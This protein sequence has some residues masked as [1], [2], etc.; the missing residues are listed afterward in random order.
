MDKTYSKQN[1]STF[2]HTQ[3]KHHLK[4]L[5]TQ[6]NVLCSSLPS[7]ISKKCSGHSRADC[8]DLC[9]ATIFTQTYKV[10]IQFSQKHSCL[11]TEMG[12][13]RKKFRGLTQMLCTQQFYAVV[14]QSYTS[15]Q[16]VT[17][18]NRYVSLGLWNYFEL[19][20]FELSART[21]V[22]LSL[23]SWRYQQKRSLVLINPCQF[24]N[25]ALIKL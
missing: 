12:K 1:Y 24:E 8:S 14:A 11:S 9:K 22:S 5:K 15:W 21:P 23:F 6:P 3:F 16:L 17:E 4:W 18:C 10:E 25:S 13:K 2:E 20:H 19:F 7:N